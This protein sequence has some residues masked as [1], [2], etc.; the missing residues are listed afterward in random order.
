MP[1]VMRRHPPLPASLSRRRPPPRPPGPL[2]RQPPRPSPAARD[3]GRGVLAAANSSV[4]IPG[5]ALARTRNLF[6]RS[7]RDSGFSPAGCPGM[8]PVTLPPGK[9]GR[10][11][12]HLPVQLPRR[13][14]A[15]FGGNNRYPAPPRRVLQLP[16]SAIK[17]WSCPAWE[18][19]FDEG[20]LVAGLVV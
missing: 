19:H 4:V 6:V 8:T 11:F 12:F 10:F 5:R 15:C 16:S 17:P 14:S 7:S 18:R 9:T 2:P 1:R 20:E 13:R 3:G